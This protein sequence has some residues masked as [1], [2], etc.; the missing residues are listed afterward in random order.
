MRVNGLTMS[1][2]LD[3]DDVSPASGSKRAVNDYSFGDRTDRV[4]LVHVSEILG[5]VSLI[6]RQVQTTA[7]T[8][9]HIESLMM[10]GAAYGEIKTGGSGDA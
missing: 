8:V 2:V 7:K 4:T 10:T 9:S 3:D 1:L 6:T 5:S